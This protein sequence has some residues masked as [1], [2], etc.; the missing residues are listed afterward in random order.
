MKKVSLLGDSIRLSYQ[1]HVRER[2]ADSAEVWAPEGN[3]MH[4]IHHLLNLGWYLTQPADVIHFN[5]GLWDCRRLARDRS[6]NIVPV[7]IFA[8]N[9]DHIITTVR[10]NT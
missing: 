3:C 1:A 7:E 10:A 2:L 9:L 4:S 5:F 8:R 6:E